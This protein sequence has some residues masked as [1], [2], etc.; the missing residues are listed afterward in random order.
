MERICEYCRGGGQIKR[1][2][3]EKKS[4]KSKYSTEEYCT[5]KKIKHSQGVFV[6]TNLELLTEYSYHKSDVSPEDDDRALH[7]NAA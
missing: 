3:E 5:T 4:D 1:I 7:R 6:S 2:W